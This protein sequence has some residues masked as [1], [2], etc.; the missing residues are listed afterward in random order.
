MASKTS[1]TN[2]TFSMLA[3][4]SDFLNSVLNNITSCVLLLDNE[5]EL[6]AY[7]EP[8]KAVF[9]NKKDEHLLYRKCG[10]ALG[11]ANQI[12]EAVDCG[13]TSKCDECELREAALFSYT[14]HEPVYKEHVVRQFYDYNNNKV[15]KDLQFSTRLFEFN[16]EKFIIMIV[17]D[18]SS[19]VPKS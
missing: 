9:S 1:M 10:E 4:S 8:L 13:K 19:R 18:I 14:S 15:D 6:R 17:E 2:H 11:C 7:N 3:G 16:M 5:M 12:E